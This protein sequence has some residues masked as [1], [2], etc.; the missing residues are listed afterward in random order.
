MFRQTY[1]SGLYTWTKEN[2]LRAINMLHIFF[3]PF[4]YVHARRTQPYIFF[5]SILNLHDINTFT[6][7]QSVGKLVDFFIENFLIKNLSLFNTF[8]RSQLSY[9]LSCFVRL[10]KRLVINLTVPSIPMN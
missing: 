4:K 8:Q 5:Q 9:I 3:S 1:D 10:S 6:F 7:I 2:K